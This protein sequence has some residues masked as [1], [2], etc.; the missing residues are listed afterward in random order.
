MLAHNAHQHHQPIYN[1]EPDMGDLI[2]P[3]HHQPPRQPPPRLHGN[4][5]HDPAPAARE[6]RAEPA[7][8]AAAPAARGSRAEP[9]RMAQE[10]RAEPALG[11]VGGPAP[12]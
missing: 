3:K 11:A 5:P 2:P 7:W 10:P 4:A 6:P 8:M 9:A 12:R 1:M